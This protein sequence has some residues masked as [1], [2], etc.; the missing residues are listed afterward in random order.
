M[1][2]CGCVCKHVKFNSQLY[3]CQEKITDRRA[4]DLFFSSSLLIKFLTPLKQQLFFLSACWF[5]ISAEV[6]VVQLCLQ[7]SPRVSLYKQSHHHTAWSK[8]NRIKWLNFYLWKLIK[9]RGASSLLCNCLSGSAQLIQ[10]LLSTVITPLL[11]LCAQSELLDS[12]QQL[13]SHKKTFSCIY[14]S[15]FPQD[16][17]SNWTF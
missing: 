11:I 12:T 6:T 4:F 2:G 14:S 15:G 1:C 13:Y 17:M 5:Y 10:L 3:W 9:Q 7:K 8:L 16:F